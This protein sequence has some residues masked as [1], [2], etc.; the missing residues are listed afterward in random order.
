MNTNTILAVK[1]D[2][3]NFHLLKKDLSNNQISQGLVTFNWDDLSNTF[4]NTNN[5]IIYKQVEYIRENIIVKPDAM[6]YAF[7][8]NIEWLIKKCIQEIESNSEFVKPFIFQK[9][10]DYLPSKGS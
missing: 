8:I 7:H 5:I 10:K 9:A 6:L 2:F 4:D 1:D 3:Q